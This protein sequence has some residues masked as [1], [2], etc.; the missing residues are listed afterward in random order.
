MRFCDLH[1]HSTASDGTDAPGRLAEVAA[2]AG[3]AAFALTDH[4]TT[5]GIPE[6]QRAADRLGIGFV[7]GVE[8]SADPDVLG[9]GRSR[10]TLH[11]LGY[12]VHHDDPGLAAIARTLRDA[13]AQ[14]NPAMVR[15]LNELGIE[16]SYDEVVA[17]AGRSR[18]AVVGRPHIA[19]VLVDRGHVGSVAEAFERFIGVRG[20]AYVRRDLLSAADAIAAIRAAGGLAAL[21]HPVQLAI[22]DQA[23]FERVLRR[24]VDAGLG[25]VETRHPDLEP[26]DTA[27]LTE[28]ADRYGL[29][30]T[31]GSD[32]HGG[33]KVNR[34]GSEQV[35]ATCWQ[36]LAEAAGG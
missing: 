27:R 23:L 12:F 8:L 16:L 4:D 34:L 36:R 5:A 10:G 18:S 14:R 6:A 26:A 11:L 13:R 25:A 15:R 32:Y 3:L 2:A 28:L 22:A 35:P 20:A 30:T 24:L 9:S 1:V 31:G 19:Q 21:A 17:V 7:P 33:R 29:L